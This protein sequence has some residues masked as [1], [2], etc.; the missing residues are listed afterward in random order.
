[1][2]PRI[3]SVFLLTAL[4]AAAQAQDA[5][6]DGEWERDVDEFFPDAE[7]VDAD[8]EP[9]H[10]AVRVVDAMTRRPIPGAVVQIP[11]HPDRGMTASE[12]RFDSVGVADHD[13]WARLRIDR[14]FGKTDYPIADAPGY[15][16]NERGRIGDE[17]IPL[18]RGV[19]V[20]VVLRDSFG[21]PVPHARLGYNLGC[22]H[23]PD[24]RVAVTDAEGRAVLRSIDP[25]KTNDV[26]V[27]APGCAYGASRLS[28]WW[29]PGAPD[30]PVQAVP[31]IS[32]EGVILR[33]RQKSR[34]GIRV[35]PKHAQRGWVVTGADGRFR[36][37]GI[38]PDSV[39]Q[40][41]PPDGPPE[42]F[43]VPPVGVSRSFQLG[44]YDR[45]IEVAVRPVDEAGKSVDGVTVTL[46]RKEDGWTDR[47]V[48][49]PAGVA[50]LRVPPGEYT[51]SVVDWRDRYLSQE[52]AVAVT[53]DEDP[54]VDIVLRRGPTVR[55][56]AS[57]IQGL[58]ASLVSATKVRY[59]DPSVIDGQDVS[60]PPD[61]PLA[62]RVYAEE[63]VDTL[64]RIIPVPPPGPERE[65][66]LLLEWFTP[67]R[68][69]ARLVGSDGQ[70]VRGWLAVGR[71]RWGVEP[72]EQV[73]AS[74]EPAAESRLSGTVDVVAFPEDRSAHG[75]RVV[76][77][78]LP[79]PT[80]REIDLGVIELPVSTGPALRVRLA[81]GMTGG[82]WDLHDGCYAL[83][84]ELADDGTF[85]DVD[86]ELAPGMALP[87]TFDGADRVQST[88]SFLASLEGP[89][90]WSFDAPTAVVRVRVEDSAGAVLPDPTVIVDGEVTRDAVDETDT[91]ELRWLAAG[92]HDLVL[93]GAGHYSRVRRIVLTDG[94][95]REI[96]VRLRRRP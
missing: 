23:I 91:F 49:H 68:V 88:A 31:G 21:A 73:A 29:R 5:P 75:E 48:V 84:G 52:I 26:W 4:A 16:P 64:V 85:D 13:G 50:I 87:F 47:E 27:Q 56:D 65:R 55:I 40:V 96:T 33:Y 35:G 8:G 7:P 9:T 15:A 10:W 81:A 60:V 2:H 36:L 63:H 18:L 76:A 93:A 22:G 51:A 82:S 92:A 58:H 32:T 90:P 59:L 44:D 53:T 62:F 72:P 83:S 41:E 66:P 74:D 71:Q 77:A 37:D 11:W 78:T 25:R 54:V 42:T 67:T 30:V 6:R 89:P 70:P 45:S 17:E 14:D 69:R 94:E 95:T 46:W 24:H 80:G 12:I 19:D 43:D 34:A 1:M 38:Q 61:G 3:A 57:R 20:P 28:G 86:G 79:E 39:I